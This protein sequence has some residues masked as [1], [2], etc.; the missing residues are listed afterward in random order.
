MNKVMRVAILLLIAFMFS[1]GANGGCFTTYDLEV[2]VPPGGDIQQAQVVIFN[3]KTG[4]K[5]IMPWPD[6]VNEGWPKDR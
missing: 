6:F 1:F 2:V 3:M 5:D 4:K